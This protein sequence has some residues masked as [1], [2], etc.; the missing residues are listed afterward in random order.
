M[1]VF[2]IKALVW[3][4]EVL[5][6]SAVLSFP[7]FATNSDK[8]I[9][10]GVASTVA[11]F[12]WIANIFVYSNL[13]TGEGGS[14]GGSLIHPSWILTAGHCF[15]NADGNAVDLNSATNTYVT[16][17]STMIEPVDAAGLIVKAEKVVV[18]PSYN[19][20]SSSNSN[21]NDI[22]LLKLS[23]PV[24]GVKTLAL[25]EASQS[26]LDAGQ[27][28]TIMGWGTTALDANGASI[29]AS[30]SL[31]KVEQKI[32]SNSECLS[33]YS[34]GISDNMLCAGGLTATDTRDSCQGDSG[35]PL[36]INSNEKFV[37]IGIT[38]FGGVNAA[39]GEPGVPGVYTKVSRYK[40]FIQSQVADA[41]FVSLAA[42]EGNTSA[43]GSTAPS[44]LSGTLD[45]AANTCAGA[46]L[47]AELNVA[48]PCL[49]VNGTAYQ[50]SLLYRG[51]LVWIWSGELAPVSCGIN[52]SVCSSADKD[53]NLSLRQL[54]I[55]Q[56]KYKA[57]LFFMDKFAGYY[58]WGYH[59]H[60]LE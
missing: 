56:T 19:P 36:V 45:S 25:I 50:S 46:Q 21:D 41:S 28:A 44:D 53:L 14:C 38:S 31:L 5:L 40:S 23:E 11:E 35:G 42:A 26:D 57:E 34:D 20:S 10:N 54:D 48:I 3:T 27:I 2:R 24:N 37:Q 52:Y 9:I 58:Y 60:S 39:C 7:V 59:S 8:R 29:N 22:A 43:S 33:V 6:L 17:N 16:L 15:L 4:S 47:D 12:P 1:M 49:V 13:E 30:N 32:V 51:D 18:H 55:N